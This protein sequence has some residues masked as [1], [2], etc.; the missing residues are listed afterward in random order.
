M[1]TMQTSALHTRIAEGREADYVREHRQI[2]DDLDPALRRGGVRSWRIWRDG[3]DLFHLLGVGDYRALRRQPAENP[4]N[5]RWQG[6]INQS[7]ADGASYEGADDGIE[8]VWSLPAQ[9]PAG[10]AA[11]QEGSR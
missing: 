4:A 3:R 9:P 10:D 5:Q 8:H 6:Q 11:V 2:P 1:R 7:L